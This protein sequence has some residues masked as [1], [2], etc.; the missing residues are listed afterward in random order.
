MFEGGGGF[1]ADDENICPSLTF[2][3][4]IIGFAV[5]LGIGILLEVGAFIALFQKDFTTF[6]VVNTLANIMALTGTLFL[7]GPKK[8]IK[9][10]FEQT[11]I[12]ATCVYLFTMVLTFVVALALK[13]DWLTVLVVIVQYLAMIWYGL[14]Y[15]PYAREAIKRCI[16][17]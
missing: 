9:K 14:S 4:R 7:S 2:T 6:A 12:V 5:C 16:G 17:L 8:Q 3:Q 15:I 13:I 1:G 10:M 11:R